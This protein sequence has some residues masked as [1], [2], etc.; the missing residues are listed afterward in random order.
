[1][2]QATKEQIVEDFAT[3]LREVKENLAST[4]NQDY[5]NLASDMARDLGAL[6][7]LHSTA[8]QVAK[9]LIINASL[10]KHVAA[11]LCA[12]NRLHNTS[13]KIEELLADA[14]ALDKVAQTAADRLAE[15]RRHD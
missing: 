6:Y 5:A 3:S 4:H 8:P 2:S 14:D 1:M 10:S 9:E 15:L 7:L 12:I 13:F 11:R